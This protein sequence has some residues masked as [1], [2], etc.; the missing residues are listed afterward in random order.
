MAVSDC[1]CF[2][3]GTKLTAATEYYTWTFDIWGSHN[4]HNTTEDN[5]AVVQQILD[6][7]PYHFVNY[8][9]SISFY[10]VHGGT[11]FGFSNGALWQNRTTAFISSYDYGSPIDETGRTT[12]LYFKMR[13]T[14]LPYV[15]NDESIP[16]PPE[17]LPRASIP[18]FS[19]HPMASL[20]ESRGK[21]TSSAS[22]LTMEAIGQSYG[23]V[24]YEHTAA[25]T[26]KG[27]LKPGDRARDRVIVYVNEKAQ[28][29]IDSQYQ[30][31]LNVSV[32]LK[33]GDKLQL[34]VENLGRVDYYSRGNDFENRVVDPFK[35]VKGDVSVGGTVLQEWDMYSMQ[36]DTIPSQCAG[37]NNTKKSLDSPL[38]YKGSFEGPR[39]TH[40]SE[41]TLDTFV[42]V[43]N[44]IKGN[45]W[46]NGFNL[47]RYWSVGPQQ[48]LYL[49][50]SLVKPGRQ[51]EVVVLELEPWQ[52][53]SAASLAVFGNSERV[54]ENHPDRD[55]PECV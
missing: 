8:S 31:P 30:H 20:F 53:E 54:W 55:C 12:D 35:G 26:M 1:H 44:G 42:T 9:A 34:L 3:L 36:L 14:I 2:A 23:Y 24:L 28:G 41:M 6:D 38:F 39:M 47:G 7:I 25:V 32:S 40:D 10:M 11:N 46:V 21:K 29:V 19:L 33:P 45:V 15:S 17:N 48:S 4:P 49:P 27:D 43:Q 22:P 18:R 13:D 5:K 16:E 37:K 50:G 51:N 52:M